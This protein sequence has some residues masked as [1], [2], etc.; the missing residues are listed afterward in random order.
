MFGLGSGLVL[1]V[2]GI[3]LFVAYLIIRIAVRHG[4]ESSKTHELLQQIYEK[5]DHK[6][7]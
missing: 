3:M 1:I 7:K 5:M 2:W 4:I 6:E